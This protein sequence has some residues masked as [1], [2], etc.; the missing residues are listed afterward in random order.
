MGGDGPGALSLSDPGFDHF[1]GDFWVRCHHADPPGSVQTS[2]LVDFGPK[3]LKVQP[4]I[5]Q[6]IFARDSRDRMGGG[7]F[8]PRLI[9]IL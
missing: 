9:I 8:Y 6:K 3:H 4:P 2:K 1:F 5:F 7:T